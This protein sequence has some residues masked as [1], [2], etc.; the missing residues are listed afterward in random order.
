MADGESWANPLVQTPDEQAATC[1]FD[2]AQKC[3]KQLHTAVS[4]QFLVH[5]ES[6]IRMYSLNDIEDRMS[7]GYDM[8]ST[9]EQARAGPAE[10]KA[11]VRAETAGKRIYLFQPT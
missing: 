5:H 10:A 1:I 6:K 9:K 4:K 8:P 2:R 3:V 11:P 7:V